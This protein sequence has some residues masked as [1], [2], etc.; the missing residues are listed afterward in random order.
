MALAHL[1]VTGYENDNVLCKLDIGKNRY[2]QLV[3]GEGRYSNKGLPA[4]ENI[5]NT[6]RIFGPLE[7]EELGRKTISVPQNVFD[8]KNDRIQLISYKDKD[9]KGIAVSDVLS[10]S[11]NDI[12]TRDRPVFSFSNNSHM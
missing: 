6:S 9:K 1:E 5:K 12:V 10:V 8:K 7:E 11:T 2:F 4:I 3:I